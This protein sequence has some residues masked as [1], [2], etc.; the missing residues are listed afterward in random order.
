MKLT[1]NADPNKSGYRGMILDLMHGQIFQQFVKLG[2]L[3][4]FWY[5]SNS[6]VPNDSRNT[7]SSFLIKVQSKY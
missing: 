3:E 2:K 7:I 4:H 5:E 6:S 1:K